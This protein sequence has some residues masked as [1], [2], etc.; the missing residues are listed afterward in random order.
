M[1]SGCVLDTLLS[2]LIVIPGLWSLPSYP[3]LPHPQQVNA[4]KEKGNLERM[5]VL[6]NALRD[7]AVASAASLNVSRLLLAFPCPSPLPSLPHSPVPCP[8]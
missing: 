7:I 2:V 4:R 3:P 1:A 8:S 5:L 6:E